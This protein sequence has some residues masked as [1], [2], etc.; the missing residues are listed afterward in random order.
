[1][2]DHTP[3]PCKHSYLD[4]MGGDAFRCRACG[5]VFSPAAELARLRERVGELEAVRAASVAYINAEP[6]VRGE[7]YRQLCDVLGGDGPEAK[8]RALAYFSAAAYRQ[9]KETK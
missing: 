8:A 6:M 1:V 2:S 7:A 9:L 4:E 5:A 3:E